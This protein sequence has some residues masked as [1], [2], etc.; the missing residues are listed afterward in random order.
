[1]RK[2]KKLNEYDLSKEHLN[3]LELKI[4]RL[5]IQRLKDELIFNQDYSKAAEIRKKQKENDYFL[6][7]IKLELENRFDSLQNDFSNF[8]EKLKIKNILLEFEENDKSYVNSVKKELA[9]KCV[10]LQLKRKELMKNGES[11]E[12]NVAMSK[13]VKTMQQLTILEIEIH[14]ERM[15][16]T[17]KLIK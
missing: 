4:Q 6:N 2:M 10:E 16:E 12:A 14:S 9:D 13:Y 3:I 1:M 17:V 11:K 15:N 5:T 7:K 8:E